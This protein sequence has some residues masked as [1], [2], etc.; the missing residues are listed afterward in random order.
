MENLNIIAKRIV[1]TESA[2]IENGAAAEKSVEMVVGELET[3]C[4]DREQKIQRLTD[5]ARYMRHELL[6]QKLI[7]M[8]EWTALTVDSDN[9]QRVSRLEGYDKMRKLCVE[10]RT[11]LEEVSEQRG[12][13][14]DATLADLLTRAQKVLN[15]PR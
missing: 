1:A 11:K 8:E 2:Y 15:E 14:A 3:L 5:L 7:D 6:Y 4:K 9:G 12:N 13:I 10:M